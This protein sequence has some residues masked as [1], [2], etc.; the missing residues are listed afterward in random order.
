MIQRYAVIFQKAEHNWAT[1]VPDLP[2][3]HQHRRDH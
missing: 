2:G 3:L 1:Y